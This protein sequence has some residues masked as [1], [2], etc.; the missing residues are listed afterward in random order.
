MASPLDLLI[1]PLAGAVAIILL[2]APLRKREYLFA[3]IAVASLIPAVFAV[4]QIIPS[5]PVSM[6][7]KLFGP[8]A[9]VEL[10]IDALSVFMCLIIL[11]LGILAVVYSVRYMEVDDGL[12]KYY[13]LLLLLIS[14]LLGVV[15]SGDLFTLFVFWEMMSISA[16]ALVSF[17]N[18]R[19]EPLEA[20][21]KYL[22]M[23]TI[24]SLIALYGMSYIYGMTGTLNIGEIALRMPALAT[25]PG[26]FS[27]I[28]IVVGFGVTAA[29]VPFHT[30]L[31]DA[32]PAAPS[33]MSALLSGVV[34]EVG[35]Y[36]IFR[37]LFTDFNPV[38][39][40]FGTLLIALG[41]VTLTV[42]NLMVYSQKDIKRFLAYSSVANV[43]FIILAA[44][45]AAYVLKNYPAYSY[46]AY[47]A[48]TGAILHIL[49]HGIGK[50]LLFFGAGS[51]TQSTGTREISLLEGIAKKMPYSGGSF[52]VGLL[53]LAGI[54]PLGGFWSKLLMIL[55]PATLLFDP[56]MVV[57]TAILLINSIL[58][59]VY[60][61]WLAQ[62]LAF[63]EFKLVEG[64]AEPRE[65]P[66]SM[67]AILI[68]L[69]VMCV[70]V[71]LALPLFLNGAGAAVSALFGR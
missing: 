47:M 58:A 21:F 12:D 10:R 56:L 52:I 34:I 39:Y 40:N 17:R 6:S 55:A 31:P 20:G 23:S 70:V 28:L 7:L 15:I 9:G 27:L 60:Y 35:I 1:Y 29:I 69:A 8:P 16:Y 71:T 41:A 48:M 53:N 26:Y 46:V 68:L 14:G 4:V 38:I 61:F 33:P 51:F 3:F 37:T 13:A 30:W 64:K 44:G 50:S 59:A 32:H 24:G 25:P 45:V 63:K 18:Y 11:G 36:A 5:L 66:A 54:P 42:G 43:G 2:S 65:A 62:R 49:N 19:W 67:L 57:S 22:V